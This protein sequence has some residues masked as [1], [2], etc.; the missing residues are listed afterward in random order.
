MKIVG[1]PNEA[2]PHFS[3]QLSSP[4][5]VKTISCVSDPLDPK[6]E[7]SFVEFMD[8]DT[9]V[10]TFQITAFDEKLC[11][12][13]SAFFDVSPLS[14]TKT[15]CTDLDVAIVPLDT[16]TLAGKNDESGGGSGSLLESICTAVFRVEYEPSTADQKQEL[17]E[18]KSQNTSRREMAIDKLRKCAAALNRIKSSSSK[19]SE[20]KD[21]AKNLAVKSGFFNKKE[22][23]RPFFLVRWYEKTVGPD[24]LL[25]QLFPIFK[26]YILFFGAVALMH[27][28]GQ[29]LALPAPL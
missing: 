19:T 21:A 10:A 7:G 6:K 2:K 20:G 27:F 25:R 1:L 5:E 12:G 13:A 4:I 9:S 22:K 15:K 17:Y 16:N 8:V 23:K 11:L 24:S 29:Q 3:I 14:D 18:L 28:Q 26:N